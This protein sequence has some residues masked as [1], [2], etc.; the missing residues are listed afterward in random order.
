M[1]PSNDSNATPGLTG[2]E[3]KDKIFLRKSTESGIAKVAMAKLAADHSSNED[4]KALGS[5][6]VTDHTQLSTEMKPIADS[7]GIRLPKDMNKIDKVEYEKLAS[8]SGDDFDR[9]FITAMVRDHRRDFREAR[10]ELMATNDPAIK[11]E[12]EKGE[13]VIRE[14]VHLIMKI[15]KDKGI[16]VPRPNAGA[17]APPPPPPPVQ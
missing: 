13:P 8:L 5:K 6:L 17:G 3:M 15:A 1:T 14:H 9:E 16:E 11:N 4:I 7:M 12:I 10:E 2:Q